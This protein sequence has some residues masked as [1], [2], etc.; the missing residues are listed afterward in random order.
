MSLLEICRTLGHLRRILL[1]IYFNWVAIHISG[2]IKLEVIIYLII[3]YYFY[4]TFN[5][6]LAIQ[7]KN[8]ERKRK[9]VITFVHF[10]W[11][12]YYILVWM[13]FSFKI[14]HGYVRSFPVWSSN[15]QS[16]YIKVVKKLPIIIGSFS[17]L[18]ILCH[19]CRGMY[20]WLITCGWIV[21]LQYQVWNKGKK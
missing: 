21:V 20:F 13:Y 6:I 2:V 10:F 9:L 8:V 17:L 3:G 18:L 16:C 5:V 15:L 12:L 19:N 14:W 7:E 1:H 11:L 4:C